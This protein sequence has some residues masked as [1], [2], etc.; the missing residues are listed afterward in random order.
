M[1]AALQGLQGLTTSSGG[2]ATSLAD[3]LWPRGAQHLSASLPPPAREIDPK[4]L[5]HARMNYKDSN[6]SNLPIQAKQSTESH[7]ALVSESMQLCEYPKFMAVIDSMLDN[8]PKDFAEKFVEGL[9][10]EEVCE[11]IH[12]TCPDE[13]NSIIKLLQESHRELGPRL[14]RLQSRMIARTVSKTKMTTNPH[15]EDKV[16]TKKGGSAG[17]IVTRDVLLQGDHHVTISGIVLDTLFAVLGVGG[18]IVLIFSIHIGLKLRRDRARIGRAQQE[19]LLER[20]WPS[21]RP[22]RRHSSSGPPAYPGT[23]LYPGPPAYPGPPPAF[24]LQR[25]TQVGNNTNNV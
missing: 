25:Y 6:H 11:T 7:G 15:V 24:E 13:L 1:I 20:S 2:S 9:E 16:S 17:A 18:L 19:R 14:H 5:E 12:N 4:V 3:R 10:K 21:E 22:S 23:P 8:M